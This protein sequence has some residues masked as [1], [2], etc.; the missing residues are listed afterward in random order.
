MRPCPSPTVCR[1]WGLETERSKVLYANLEIQRSFTQRRFKTLADAKGIV[2][3]AGWLALW[4]LRGHATS[5]TEMFPRILD[6]IAD[7]DYGLIILD[8]IYK[9]YGGMDNENGAREMAALMNSIEHLA[10]ET[11]AAVAF[12]AHYSKGNQANKEAI[13]RVSGSGVFARDPD[14]LLNFTRHQTED[15]Y[16]VEATLRNFPPMTPFAVR[17]QFP[18][19]CAMRVSTRPS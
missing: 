4:N 2:Q 6:R 3:E 14:S 11:G 8:P 17:W 1:G 15:C 12:A 19:L 9:L 16:T 5:H 10:V 7:G 13:D 18:L